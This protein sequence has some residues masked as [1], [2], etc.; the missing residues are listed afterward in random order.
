VFVLGTKPS[1]V[2]QRGP[3]GTH[4]LEPRPVAVVCGGPVNQDH[5]VIN[6]PTAINSPVR[7][8]EPQ[9][10]H[11]LESRPAALANGVLVSPAQIA[12][13]AP[14]GQPSHAPQ[15]YQQGTTATRLVV[16]AS[17]VPVLAAHA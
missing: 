5:L 3:Q 7:Q 12:I 9:G 17:G 1:R 13:S 16:T 4:V 14:T 6:A 11:V 15:Q 8:R 10:T 2:R